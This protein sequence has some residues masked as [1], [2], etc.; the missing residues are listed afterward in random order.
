MLVFIKDILI[1]NNTY[2]SWHELL[3][4]YHTMV[5]FSIPHSTLLQR[6]PYS[7]NT[8]SLQICPRSTVFDLYSQKQTHSLTLL[9]PG[10]ILKLSLAFIILIHLRPDLVQDFTWSLSRIRVFMFTHNMS[11][12]H[13]WAVTIPNFFQPYP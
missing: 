10:L 5:Y 12:C 3:L 13:K 9:N 7:H 6:G 11:Q 1:K 8:I 2:K 4:Y